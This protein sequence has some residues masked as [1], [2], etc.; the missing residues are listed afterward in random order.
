MSFE[1]EIRRARERNAPLS[2][3]TLD[4]DSSGAA[5][6][7]PG[8][9]TDERLLRRVAHTARGQLRGCDTCVRYAGDEFILI[10]PGIPREGAR[11]VEDRLRVALQRISS[12]PLPGRVTRVRVFLGSATYPDDGEGFE[13][14]L[15]AA[16][17]RRLQDRGADPSSG[18]RP[19]GLTSFPVKL[20]VLTRN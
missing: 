13:H 8:S 19:Q 3:L 12:A 15:A 16:D 20:R 10:L 1:E 14:L 7:A 4:L 5:G 18:P 17:A 2:I 11:K 9:P 6:E